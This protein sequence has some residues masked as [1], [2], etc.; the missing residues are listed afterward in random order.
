MTY[1]FALVLTWSGDTANMQ[2]FLL[3]KIPFVH[4]FWTNI[5]CLFVEEFA[6]FLKQGQD[7][8]KLKVDFQSQGQL[9]YYFFLIRRWP[10]SQFFLHALHA[11]LLS[12]L[13]T[14]WD[15]WSKFLRLISSRFVI[16][17]IH[18]SMAH[19]IHMTLLAVK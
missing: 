4:M 2:F 3:C 9:R 18:L 1:N 12:T 13:C 5:F 10:I 11:W 16:R 14:Q 15:K 17:F 7:V 19:L 8:R 6:N